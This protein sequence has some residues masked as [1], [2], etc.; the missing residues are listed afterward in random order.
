MTG[1]RMP[2]AVSVT[3]Y[4]VN[5]TTVYAARSLPIYIRYESDWGG[6]LGT[7]MPSVRFF[8]LDRWLTTWAVG[9]KPLLD[10]S[11]DRILRGP[12]RLRLNLCRVPQEFVDG[13]MYAEPVAD[14]SNLVDLGYARHR[15]TR[16][17]GP[18]DLARAATDAV[19]YYLYGR[20]EIAAERLIR[21]ITSKG[22]FS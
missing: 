6:P 14:P 16:R 7:E 5:G 8:Y 2:P 17:Y 3:T 9:A 21:D 11:L 15:P 1:G 18:H 10:G 19:L 22:I 13:Y 20:P 12:V 4:E